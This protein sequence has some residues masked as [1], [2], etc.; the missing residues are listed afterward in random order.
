MTSRRTPLIAAS[1]LGAGA[2]LAIGAP[3]AA[4][5]HVTVDPSTTAAGA[6]SVL[7]FSMGHGCEGSPTTSVAFTI[8]ESITSVTPTVNPGWT[9]EKVMEELDAPA[10]SSHGDAVTERVAQVVYT[11]DAPFPDG[12]R[13]TFALQTPLPDAAGETILFPALQTCEVGSTDWADSDPEAAAPAP[14]ITV[15]DAGSGDGHG[16]GG[17]SDEPTTD[18]ASNASP[19]AAAAEPDVLARVLGIAGLVVGVVGVVIAVAGRRR[20]A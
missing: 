16:H 2:L 5:A 15:T 17:E 11:A 10:E 8:P 1:A 14:S 6:Y 13:T 9:I 12:Y 20:S 3:L 4:S 18:S 19:T 7:T